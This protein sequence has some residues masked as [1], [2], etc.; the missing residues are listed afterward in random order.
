VSVDGENR[1]ACVEGPEF[2]GHQ[3]DF[4]LLADRLGT[5]RAFEQAANENRERCHVGLTRPAPI[6]T[7]VAG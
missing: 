5:Y 2:D 6:E 1:Y 3:V 7:E 4:D